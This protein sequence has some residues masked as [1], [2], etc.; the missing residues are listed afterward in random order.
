MVKAKESIPRT[1]RVIDQL[2]RALALETAAAA[3]V[4]KDPERRRDLEELAKLYWDDAY[5]RGRGH[6]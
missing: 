2:A 4:E 1:P 6:G 5:G 3:A